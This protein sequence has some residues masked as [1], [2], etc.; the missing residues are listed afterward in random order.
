MTDEDDK[1][2]WRVV[3]AVQRLLL[4]R[5][6]A[7]RL[8]GLACTAAPAGHTRPQ[9]PEALREL[10]HEAELLAT[11]VQETAESGRG[12]VECLGAAIAAAYLFRDVRDA[13]SCGIVRESTGIAAGGE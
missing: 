2:F 8:C 1:E 12:G 3:A 10:R 7:E 5:A 6:E 4:L 9:L 11:E 13:L